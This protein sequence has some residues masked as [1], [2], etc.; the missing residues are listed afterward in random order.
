MKFIEFLKLIV[1]PIMFSDQITHNFNSSI[2]LKTTMKIYWKIHSLD[3]E[4]F[5][6]WRKI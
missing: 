1:D 2:Y 4:T 5:F 3:L 6:L